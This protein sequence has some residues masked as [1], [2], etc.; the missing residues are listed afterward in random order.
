MGPVWVQGLSHCV[1]KRAIP[2]ASVVDSPSLWLA[3]AE[4]MQRRGIEL[5]DGSCEHLGLQR[6][7]IGRMDLKLVQGISGRIRKD[8]FGSKRCRAARFSTVPPHN[9]NTWRAVRGLQLLQK[10]KL[11]G[12]IKQSFLRVPC[13]STSPKRSQT[14]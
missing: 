11:A 3:A 10:I 14:L 1:F 2:A 12:D 7:A 8:G 6:S 9:L 13:T 4:H 5:G